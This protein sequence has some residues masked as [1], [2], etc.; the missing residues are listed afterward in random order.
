MATMV[1]SLL[2]YGLGH[3]HGTSLATWQL[4][5]LVIGI[6]NVAWSIVFV[7]ISHFSAPSIAS[8]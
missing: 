3:S 7:C 1:G 6:L 5:F 4:I 2:G 8:H